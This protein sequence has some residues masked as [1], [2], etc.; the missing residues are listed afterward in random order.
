MTIRPRSTALLIILPLIRRITG[1]IHCDR[2]ALGGPVYEDCFA[3]MVHS[4]IMH[5]EWTT[6]GGTYWFRS[7]FSTIQQTPANLPLAELPFS[8]EY[9][10][11]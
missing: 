2:E 9:S 5:P 6:P 11:L 7:A 3:L 8:F 4:L 1:V 10:Q